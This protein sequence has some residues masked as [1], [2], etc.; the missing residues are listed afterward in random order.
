MPLSQH[1]AL[2]FALAPVPLAGVRRQEHDANAV[3][4]K[5]RQLKTQCLSLLREELVRHLHQNTRAVPRFRIGPACTSMPQVLQHLQAHG[6]DLVRLVALDAG[7]EA[8]A[9]G[10][11]LELRIVEALL[12]E[13]GHVGTAH[14]TLFSV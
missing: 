8:N 2:D 12:D 11:S 5:R 4:A 10:V 14:N 7:Y 9:T 13:I 6:D 1:N 3:V